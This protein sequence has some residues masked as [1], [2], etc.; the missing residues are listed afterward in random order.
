[1]SSG[2]LALLDDVS[3]LVKAGAASIDDISA[4]VAK[5][6]GKVSGL[7]IDDAAVTPKYVVGLDAKRELSIIYNIAK[8]SVLNKLL[9]LA[10]ATLLLGYFL[11][12]VINP[13]LMIGGS[14]LC[15]EGF[16]KVYDYFKK[17]KKIEEKEVLNISP[18]ELEEMRIGSAVR[19][20]FILSAEIMAI[21]YSTL[22]GT[23][24]MTQIIVMFLVA[25]GITIL[26]YGVV[27]II[28][29][30]DDVGLYLI[31]KN[32]KGFLNSFGKG[33]IKFMPYFLQALSFIGT[34]AMFVVGFEI[35]IHNIHVFEEFFMPLSSYIKYPLIILSGTIWG[36][37]CDII[38]KPVIKLFKKS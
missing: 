28:V 37:L 17:N 18:E 6:T 19:T 31:E 20:D 13:I 14:Y 22:V 10:P 9:Y 7:I 4:Q 2:L 34:L 38:V 32:E 3:A 29:K 26:V 21:T 35:I 16:H 15:V 23:N 12:A 8:K 1:M 5:S 36:G 11:P 27:A 30:M 33:I 24:L 25:V